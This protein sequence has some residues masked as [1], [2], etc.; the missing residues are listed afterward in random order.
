VIEGN[1]HIPFGDLIL[2]GL[3][4]DL[5]VFNGINVRSLLGDA[6]TILGGGPLPDPSLSYQDFFLLINDVDQ[7][8]NTGPVSSFADA[9]LELPPG[10]A[11]VPE[12]GRYSTLGDVLL[13]L[14]LI[15]ATRGRR[16]EPRLERQEVLPVFASG[17]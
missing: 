8:F 17:P 11:A 13:L 15:A 3:S 16:I 2:T 4:G 10:A 12:T 9:N 7:S 6:E 14:G 5:A 1:L